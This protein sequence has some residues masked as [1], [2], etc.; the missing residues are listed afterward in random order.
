MF[1]TL[2][3]GMFAVCHHLCLTL[4]FVVQM[5]K[6]IDLFLFAMENEELYAGYDY[7]YHIPR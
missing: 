2:C 6:C 4:L 3:C 1:L 5:I 7:N